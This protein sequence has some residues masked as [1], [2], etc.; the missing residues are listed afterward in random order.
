ME[1]TRARPAGRNR[2][3]DQKGVEKIITVMVIL[4]NGG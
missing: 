1:R 2:L 4:Q 3:V